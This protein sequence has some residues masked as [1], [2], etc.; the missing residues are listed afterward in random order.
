M[1][2][3]GIALCAMSLAAAGALQAGEVIE[4]EQLTKAQLAEALKAA[5]E[6]T[7]VEFQG[8]SKTK[9]QWRSDFLAK[10]N[11]PD[12]AKLKALAEARKA[13]FE[14]R[15]KALQ[16]EQDRNIADQNGQAKKEFDELTSQP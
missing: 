3:T 11:P 16:D 1:L 13:E 10:H 9:A 14:A 12:V 4:V 2:K 6:D 15:A 8:E 5:S 7:V